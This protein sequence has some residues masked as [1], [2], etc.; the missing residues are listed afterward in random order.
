MANIFSPIL[1]ISNERRN[2]HNEYHPTYD[3]GCKKLTWVDDR[4]ESIENLR[5]EEKLL[6][7]YTCISFKKKGSNVRVN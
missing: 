1:L 3:I 6:D 4:H 5:I 2:K 7:K